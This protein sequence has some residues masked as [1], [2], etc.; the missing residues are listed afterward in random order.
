MKLSARNV[1][2][3]KIVSIKKGPISSLVVIEVAPGVKLTSTITAD[4]AKELKLAKGKAEIRKELKRIEKVFND[5]GFIPHGDHRIPEDVPYENYKYYT[6]EKLKMMGWKDWDIKSVF[7]LR[8]M[9]Q[10]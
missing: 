9:K 2:P 6:M 10:Q 5:G 1:L 4:A 3:G 7:P 8:E